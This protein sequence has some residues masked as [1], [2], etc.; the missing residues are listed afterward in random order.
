MLADGT[1]TA[2]LPPAG[3]T[4]AHLTTGR[5]QEHQ[6]PEATIRPDGRGATVIFVA[7][8]NMPGEVQHVHRD[9]A[10]GAGLL[11]PAPATGRFP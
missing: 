3:A 10:S 6:I 5:M 8:L 2:G 4:D 9:D 7:Y 1:A 11:P